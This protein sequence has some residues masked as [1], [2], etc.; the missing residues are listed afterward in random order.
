M[1]ENA[2]DYFDVKLEG[3]QVRLTGEGKKYCI[4]LIHMYMYTDWTDTSG[5]VL[6]P[7]QVDLNLQKSIIPD[8][9]RLPGLDLSLPPSSLSLS[10]CFSV[11]PS[12]SFP[13]SLSIFHIP[14][15]M[16]IVHIIIFYYFIFI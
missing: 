3:V 8:D 13:I 11:S 10:L 1:D 7:L 14:L 16:Y 4:L 5:T 9:T 12:P 2:Y 15:Y 6:K